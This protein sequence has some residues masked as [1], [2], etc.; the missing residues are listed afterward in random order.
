MRTGMDQQN[1]EVVKQQSGGQ[2]MFTA[3]PRDRCGGGC[4]VLAAIFV[5]VDMLSCWQGTWTKP[6]HITL[7]MFAA[8]G[9]GRQAHMACWL[10]GH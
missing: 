6:R 5:L 9:A 1:N 10:G 7:T 8:M 4:Y 3:R 2:G